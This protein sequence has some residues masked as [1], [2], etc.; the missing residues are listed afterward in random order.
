VFRVVRF[1]GYITLWIWRLGFL[2]HKNPRLWRIGKER[3]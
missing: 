1:D 2:L 3:L